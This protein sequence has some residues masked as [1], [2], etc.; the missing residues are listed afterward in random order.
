MCWYEK[1]LRN[2]LSEKNQAIKQNVSV[3]KNNIYDYIKT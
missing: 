3:Y 2:S 1:Y